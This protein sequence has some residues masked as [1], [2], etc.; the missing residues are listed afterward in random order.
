M[1]LQQLYHLHQMEKLL[2]KKQRGENV[3]KISIPICLSVIVNSLVNLQQAK[4]NLSKKEYERVYALYKYYDI[5]KHETPMT[6]DEYIQIAGH[7]IDKFQALAPWE[8]YNG[9]G[10]PYISQT[11]VSQALNIQEHIYKW[12]DGFARFFDIN[13]KSGNLFAAIQYIYGYYVLLERIGIWDLE[14]INGYNIPKVNPKSPYFWYEHPATAEFP[15]MPLYFDHMP[16]S[17]NEEKILLAANL[18]FSHILINPINS[19]ENDACRRFEQSIRFFANII[20]K[21]KCEKDLNID[22]RRIDLDGKTATFND[23]RM[24]LMIDLRDAL[25]RKEIN[26]NEVCISYY[27]HIADWCGVESKQIY[28]LSAYNDLQTWR[29]LALQKQ[30]PAPFSNYTNTILNLTKPL[31]GKVAQ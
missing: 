18:F 16:D 28:I 29:K 10:A 24:S 13:V 26:W 27:G 3:S 30:L 19:T 8:K 20:D 23:D 12:P 14:Y 31:G 1:G 15:E 11:T 2:A 6:V 9:S 5:D 4:N 17:L 21:S 25:S 22:R 7:I